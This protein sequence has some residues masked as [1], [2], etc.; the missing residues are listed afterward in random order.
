MVHEPGDLF[1]ESSRSAGGTSLLEK[2]QLSFLLCRS[3][4]VCMVLDV[5]SEISFIFSVVSRRRPTRE[6]GPC[7][8]CQ[9][10]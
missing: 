4:H 6:E 10:R 3:N 9:K 1:F 2:F 7:G 8:A 5:D